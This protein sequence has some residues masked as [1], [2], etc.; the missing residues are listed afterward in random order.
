ME[1][2]IALVVLT[3]I[4]VFVSGDVMA[5]SH[6][7]KATDQSLEITAANYY[8]GFMKADP[9]FWSPDW[10]T[11]PVDACDDQLPPYTDSYPSPP[12]QANWHD[13]AYCPQAPA[14]TNPAPNASP[15]SVQ[16]MWNVTQR[17]DDLNVAD[18]TVWIRRDAGSPI[19]EY[20]GL[21]YLTPSV[22]TATPYP[23]PTPTSSP[24]GP[25]SPTPTPSPT[26]KPPP[27]PTPSPTPI[28]V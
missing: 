11:G 15:E 4:F 5:I 14:F 12:A 6:G 10:S 24:T 27:T 20:H 21:R 18:L 28:G 17:P 7:D 8:L 23:T 22:Q 26:I 25:P 13:Y 19:F 2:L 9:A 1:V 16:Y 3:L